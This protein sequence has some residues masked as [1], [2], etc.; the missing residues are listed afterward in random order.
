M[1]G[2]IL[3]PCRRCGRQ[4][5]SVQVREG[6][7]LDCRVELALSEL[8]TEHARLWRKRE[9]YRT[10]GANADS[11]SRQIARVED[12]M[13][14]RIRELVPNQEQAVE[15]LRKALEQARGARYEIRRS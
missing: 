14:E 6:L 10:Q 15:Q 8:R 11:V 5:T 13:A 12:R 2:S 9:R 1:T 4:V 7:C 3:V